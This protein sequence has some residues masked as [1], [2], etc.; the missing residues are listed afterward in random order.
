MGRKKRVILTDQ[1][2]RGLA[3]LRAWMK[4]LGF[5]ADQLAQVSG[6]SSSTIHKWIG[7][8]RPLPDKLSTLESVCRALGHPVDD[9][10]SEHPGPL[11][12]ELTPAAYAR[13]TYP[14]S[15]DE[16]LAQRLN[17]QLSKINQEQL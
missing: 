8:K 12:R 17:E 16:D 13:P 1:Q 3:N 14:G 5:S 4:E 11:R 2:E 6:E 15:L 7:R 10:F 9:L